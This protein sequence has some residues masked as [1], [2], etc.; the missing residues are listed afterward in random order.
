MLV[1]CSQCGSRIAHTAKVCPKCG[2]EDSVKVPIYQ[3]WANER[4]A[5]V[6][7]MCL[8]IALFVWVCSK[9]MGIFVGASFGILKYVWIFMGISM[10]ANIISLIP[11]RSKYDKLLSK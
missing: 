9:F 8:G 7:S 1:K 5:V 4:W 11:T 10:L 2:A 3:E 6:I